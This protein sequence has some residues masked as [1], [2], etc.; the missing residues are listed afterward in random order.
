M[1]PRGEGSRFEIERKLGERILDRF[2]EGL[3]KS[4]L[5]CPSKGAVWARVHDEKL[6][7]IGI[8]QAGYWET[9]RRDAFAYLKS[10][11]AVCV[12]TKESLQKPS[13]HQHAGHIRLTLIFPTYNC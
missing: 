8:N 13:H 12:G 5:S 7:K 1:E 4:L 9:M 11:S 2:K 3:W 10:E 6:L